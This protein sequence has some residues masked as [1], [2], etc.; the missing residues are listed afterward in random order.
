MDAFIT[1]LN[2]I[3]DII[4]NE[5]NGVSGFNE[6]YGKKKHELQTLP[7]TIFSRGTTTNGTYQTIR[8]RVDN[9][10]HYTEIQEPFIVRGGATIGFPTPTKDAEGKPKF[11]D[12]SPV[13][14]DGKPVPVK[15]KTSVRYY[16]T[17]R[18]TENA[19][20][21]SDAYF[22]LISDLVTECHQKF[23]LVNR[24]K[25]EGLD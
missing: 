12:E 16:F 15:R 4:R 25:R 17:D 7:I 13:L 23:N 24:K 1:N 19:M 5:F 11:D 22:N 3:W 20:V 18:P 6:W 14:V 10:S 8:G 2:S 21:L 9:N